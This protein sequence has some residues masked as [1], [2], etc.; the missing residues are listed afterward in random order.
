MTY[1]LILALVFGY[2]LGSIPFGLLLTRAAGLGD[3]RKIGSGNIGATNV[4][5]TG[6]KGLA[7]ATLLLDALKGTAAVLISAHFA[8]ETAVWAGLGAFLGHLF[9]VW[10]GFKGG[11]GVATYLGVLI[12]L[13]WPV[14]LIFAV[15]W[16]AM[17]FLLRYSSL[18]AL[19]A[20]VIVP[21]A[22]YFMGTPQVA[23]LFVVMSV[24]VFIKHR[25]NISRLLA[26]T[27]GKIGA[28]G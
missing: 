5:R 23:L 9:P 25:A 20:A 14:A 28:K 16:L 24:I 7:A 3:V 1:G 26:G 21:I 13:A 19:T 11:K 27:E 8:P 15:V 10:L 4:L 22:L 6:N 17:A 2:L 12:G 18:A